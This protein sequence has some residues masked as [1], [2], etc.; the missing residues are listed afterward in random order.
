VSRI[1]GSGREYKKTRVAGAQR[2]A[3]NENRRPLLAP[4]DTA[5]LQPAP[6]GPRSKLAKRFQR[7]LRCE[8][9]DAGARNERWAPAAAAGRRLGALAAQRSEHASRISPCLAGA[10]KLC[11]L[12]EPSGPVCQAASP[13]V[14]LGPTA[15]DRSQHAPKPFRAFVAWLVTLLQI[16]G[17]LHF[18]LVPHAFS[19]ALGGVVHVHAVTRPHAAAPRTERA[20]SPNH[21]SGGASLVAALL[22]CAV[23][24]CPTA[25]VPASSLLGSASAATGWVS[26]GNV[27]L[28]GE[29]AACSPEAQRVFLSAPKTSPPV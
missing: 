23:D 9:S 19:V 5:K 4:Y 8:G 28:L 25:D 26:F 13:A 11:A 27:R 3:A 2:S 10:S 12:I 6:L 21:E 22:S 15:M 18:A 20:A 16:A 7:R 29:R 24:L 17:A 1:H 14:L